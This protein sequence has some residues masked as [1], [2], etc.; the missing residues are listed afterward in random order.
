M[1]KNL[2]PNLQSRKSIITRSTPTRN[3]TKSIQRS[4]WR[5]LRKM[6]SLLK[7]RKKHQLKSQKRSQLRSLLRKRRKLSQLRR[8]RRRSLNKKRLNPAAP[9]HPLAMM[10]INTLQSLSNKPQRLLKRQRSKSW[11][12]NAHRSLAPSALFSQSSSCLNRAAKT[13]HSCQRPLTSWTQR[14]FSSE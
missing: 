6:K 13:S 12:K 8:K 7:R 14:T 10:T 2:R 3:I 11:R 1:I 5:M 9:H 4:I